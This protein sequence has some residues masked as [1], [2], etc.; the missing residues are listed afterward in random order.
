[1]LIAGVDEA[2]RGAL[3]GPVVA[4][5]VILDPDH[6]ESSLYKDS[7]TLSETQRHHLY[8]HLKEHSKAIGIGIVNQVLIDRLNILNA[9]MLAIKRAVLSLKKVSPDRILIDG[10]RKPQIPGYEDIQTIIKGDAKVPCISAASIVAKVV[11]DQIM[12][13]LHTHFSQYQFQQNKGYGTAFHYEQILK[14]G[15]SSIH[16]RTFNL[17]KQLELF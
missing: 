6:P 1:M 12:C 10:N 14:F 16:R 7:K 9:T 2:G 5:A 8:L 15:K 17:T 3:A 13:K 11:R 4:A